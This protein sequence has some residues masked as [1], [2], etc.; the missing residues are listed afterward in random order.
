[1]CN[2][3]SVLLS[4]VTHVA[5]DLRPE[6]RVLVVGTNAVLLVFIESLHNSPI[7]GGNVRRSAALALGHV[8][9]TNVSYFNSSLH[10]H[11]KS[12]NDFPPT[13]HHGV[14]TSS[15]SI[16]RHRPSPQA[17]NPSTIPLKDP[18]TASLPL[19]LPRVVSKII[20]ILQ[21]PTRL[22][23]TRLLGVDDPLRNGRSRNR[24]NSPCPQATTITIFGTLLKEPH[25]IRPL[26][27]QLSP[28]L[29]LAPVSFPPLASQRQARRRACTHSVAPKRSLHIASCVTAP[30]ITPLSRTIFPFLPSNDPQ[31]FLPKC[32]LFSNSTPNIISCIRFFHQSNFAVLT[33]NFLISLR[34][35]TTNKHGLSST[36]SVPPKPLHASISA[37][38]ADRSTSPRTLLLETALKNCFLQA[39][40][41]SSFHMPSQ[42]EVAE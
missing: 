17:A 15:G 20:R 25:F 26:K 37:L 11:D 35:N 10:L 19:K 42:Q 12:G 38:A 28:P 18:S 30:L 2:C 29:T 5:P 13:P 14:L 7:V 40:D 4:P 39:F 34:N 36:K 16:W 3:N 27:P 9:G 21:P 22:A 32:V 1:M 8:Q 24:D 23:A 33:K 6:V 31:V 41:M